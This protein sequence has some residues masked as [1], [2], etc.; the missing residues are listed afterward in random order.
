MNLTQPAA[1]AG[2][3]SWDYVTAGTYTVKVSATDSGD[4]KGGNMTTGVAKTS[5]TIAASASTVSGLVTTST[6][7]PISGA[8]V[9]LTKLNGVV[10]YLAYTNAS[11]NYTFSGVV[12]NTYTLKAVKSGVTFPAPV[13]I[14]TS[15]VF[16]APTIIATT[17]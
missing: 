3:W 10:K 8:A 6:G 5:V 14:T 11:G 15:G 13:S 7:T 1:G 17:P 12:D 2:T 4:G 16:T 9:T